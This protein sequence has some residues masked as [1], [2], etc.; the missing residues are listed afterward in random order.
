M[1]EG[2]YEQ[3]KRIQDSELKRIITRNQK[4]CGQLFFY[5]KTQ[6]LMA[7]NVNPK[8]TD[9]QDFPADIYDDL[10]E[11]EA[12]IRKLVQHWNLPKF[13]E[14]DTSPQ[15]LGYEMIDPLW[16]RYL[17]FIEND[18][19]VPRDSVC[20]PGLW[21]PDLDGGTQIFNI[22]GFHDILQSI[23]LSS[24]Q[25]T[26]NVDV[27]GKGFFV[28]SF[29]DGKWQTFFSL[30]ETCG[31][32]HQSCFMAGEDLLKR[33]EYSPLWLRDEKSHFFH[34]NIRQIAALYLDLPLLQ[35]L[36]NVPHEVNCEPYIT[37]SSAE[38]IKKAYASAKAYLE[39]FP[40]LDPEQFDPVVLAAFCKD[41]DIVKYM[42]IEVPYWAGQY[43]NL[44]TVTLV[45]ERTG[46]EDILK[47]LVGSMQN[48]GIECENAIV[49]SSVVLARLGEIP[50]LIRW[51][52]L[53]GPVVQLFQKQE[54]VWHA[55]IRQ[56]NQRRATFT[57]VEERELNIYQVTVEE[58][59]VQSLGFI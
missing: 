15:W 28:Q 35:R 40:Q 21:Q 22:D 27:L 37:Y 50:T 8:P 48:L 52:H 25:I 41:L 3:E 14:N 6:H 17:P 23:I 20:R 58:F 18:S 39:G 59:C 11:A 29:L 2:L 43:A 46:Q 51:L 45:L 31:F 13:I 5:I 55:V 49:E 47:F 57:I 38:G 32:P 44:A 34:L 19:R 24:N 36:Q 16:F 42:L 10:L 30:W 9:W 12:K 26:A 56:L 53:V 1:L 7:N 54:V 33:L 4:D